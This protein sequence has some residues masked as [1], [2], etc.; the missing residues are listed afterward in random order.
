[1]SLKKAI[2]LI[3]GGTI[4]VMLVLCAALLVPVSRSFSHLEKAEAGED[5][6]RVQAGLEAELEHLMRNA[7]D[8]AVWDDT[9]AFAAGAKPDYADENLSLAAMT[10]LKVDVMA[11]YDRDGRMLWGKAVDLDSGEELALPTLT[12]G[13]LGPGDVLRVDHL[14][15]GGARG[16]VATDLGPMLVVAA[17]IRPHTRELPPNGTF[18]LGRLLDGQALD[19]IRRLTSVDFDIIGAGPDGAPAAAALE[20]RHADD[21]ISRATLND[22]S[23]RPAFTLLS[24]TPRDISEVGNPYIKISLGLLLAVGLADVALMWL[25]L[26]RLVLRRVRVLTR[27]VDAIANSGRLDERVPPS[28][29]DELGALAREFNRMLDRLAEARKQLLE[30]SHRSGMAEMAAGVLH[31]LRNGLSPLVGRIDAL[32]ERMRTAAGDEIGRAVQEVRDPATPEERRRRLIDYVLVASTSLLALKQEAAVELAAAAGNARQ[33]GDVLKHQ[34]KFIYSRSV[35]EPL[36]P[37]EVVA[38]A[39]GLLSPRLA[40]KAAIVVDPAVEAVPPVLAERVTLVQIVHN[41]LVNAAEAIDR[42]GHDDGRI[43]IAPAGGTAPGTVGIRVTDNGIGIAPENIARIFQRGYTTKAGGS[44]G[45]GLHW[46]ANA[47]SNMQGRM[48]VA[49]DGS[50]RG[51]SFEIIL[52]AAEGRMAA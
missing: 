31:N 43:V 17:A 50:G 22:L 35:I 16:L 13:A 45:L 33:L 29:D 6:R 37:Q 2:T 42:A 40:R 25:L 1:M 47:A 14:D 52:P 10:T 24:Y 3:L 12:G 44:G 11:L 4:L 15:K 26:Q 46:C 34:D 8:W 20:A 39:V 32:A 18:L 23:G 30:Q 38:D 49:S 41:L 48:R 7:A 51:A 36:R 27:H 5:N 21:E 28:G 9:Y 19:A